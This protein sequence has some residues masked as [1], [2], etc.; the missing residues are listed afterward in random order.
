MVRGH[1]TLIG[2][3]APFLFVVAPILAS[4]LPTSLE[5]HWLLGGALDVS[6][7]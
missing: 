3:T 7:C 4:V 2:L 6:C 1:G 5:C